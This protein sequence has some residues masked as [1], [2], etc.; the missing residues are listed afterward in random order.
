[1]NHLA[2]LTRF[3]AVGALLTSCQ[4]FASITL[5][6]EFGGDHL[7]G[8]TRREYDIYEAGK[9]TTPGDENV[10]TFV[11]AIGIHV[12]AS[13]E[14]TVGLGDYVAFCAELEQPIENNTGYTFDLVEVGVLSQGSSGNGASNNISPSGFGADAAGRL[15]YLF[16]QHFVS[17]TMT[18]WGYAEKA[19]VLVS[20]F[21]MAVWELTHDT[22][23][24][25]KN[26]TPGTNFFLV[27]PVS[28]AQKQA[29]IDLAQ[30]WVTD[31][32]AS[33]ID[34]S[35]VSQKWKVHG[36]ENSVAQDLVFAQM[37]PEPSSAV[38]LALGGLSLTLRRRRS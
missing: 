2:K 11:P 14:P 7:T 17:N 25:L 35:Y 5:T 24:D 18:D 30:T 32:Q 26:G 4:A 3:L 19:P 21:Q 37:V 6:T 31:V 9:W 10:D 29:T 38:L 33:G 1:M 20:A 8:E 23:Y 15:R 12:T 16:D 13:D 28:N 36:L 27:S 34:A 22:D